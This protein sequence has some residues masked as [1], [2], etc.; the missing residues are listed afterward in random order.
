MRAVHA[1]AVA[2][3]AP[4]VAVCIHQLSAPPP[5]L[6]VRPEESQL[7]GVRFGAS[8][9]L[10]ACGAVRAEAGVDVVGRGDVGN[11]ADTGEAE[12]RHAMHGAQSPGFKLSSQRAECLHRAED[13]E[14]Q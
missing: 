14:N 11:Q 13:G 8:D 3:G 6:S 7:S 4:V 1:R 12:H 5:S 9:L 2:L 10:V